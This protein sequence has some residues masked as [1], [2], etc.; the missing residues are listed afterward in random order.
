MVKKTLFLLIL[1]LAVYSAILIVRPHYNYYGFKS[2]LRE[3]LRVNVI[4]FQKGVRAGI[5][6]IAENYNIPINE[7]D[8]YLKLNGQYNAKISWEET[9]DFLT[10]YQK[11]Y[12]F[13]I[14]TSKPR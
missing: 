10:L 2:D 11:T 8:I 4:T 3:Y 13:H 1:A 6:D 5:L 12:K 7:D 9:V 14:D